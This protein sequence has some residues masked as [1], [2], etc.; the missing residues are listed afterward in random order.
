MLSDPKFRAA[1]KAASSYALGRDRGQ[2]HRVCDSLRLTRTNRLFV[3]AG[4]MVD[5]ES[6]A[7]FIAR[8]RQELEAAV[9]AKS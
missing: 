8:E 2:L 3:W 5:R 1:R 4:E 7:Y 6:K 9:V